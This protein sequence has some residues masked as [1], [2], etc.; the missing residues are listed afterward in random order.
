M[1]RT[2]VQFSLL[3]LLVF[4]SMTGAFAQ[5]FANSQAGE[6]IGNNASSKMSVIKEPLHKPIAQADPALA[7]ALAAQPPVNVTVMGQVITP[8]V[9]E[10]RYGAPD[11]K[12]LVEQSGGLTRYCAHQFFVFKANED[13]L[14]LDARRNA[15]YKFEDGDLLLVET[16]ARHYKTLGTSETRHSLADIH[17]VT[18]VVL[19]NVLDRP[20]LLSLSPNDAKLAYLLSLLNQDRSAMVG[21]EGIAPPNASAVPPDALI[22]PNMIFSGSIIRFEPGA[23]NPNTLPQLPEPIQV[24]KSSKVQVLSG[25]TE[26]SES[27]WARDP[28]TL[29]VQPVK[30]QTQTP[31]SPDPGNSSRIDTLEETQ[32]SENP[33][34]A[35]FAQ[36]EE[37]SDEVLNS[38]APE[39]LLPAVK[40]SDDR[41]MLSAQ[42]W[43]IIATFVTLMVLFLSAWY[44]RQRQQK[45]GIKA[46]NFVESRI[47]TSPETP[48][49][50]LAEAKTSKEPAEPRGVDS[51]VIDQSEIANVEDESTM[52]SAEKTEVEV[53][54]QVDDPH[55]DVLELEVLKNEGPDES[56]LKHNLAAYSFELSAYDSARKGDFIDHET[57][58]VTIDELGSGHEIETFDPVEW[59]R[60][61]AAQTIGS[62]EG[63]VEDAPPAESLPAEAQHESEDLEE[64]AATRVQQSILGTPWL[65]ELSS[66]LDPQQSDISLDE[67]PADTPEAGEEIKEAQPQASKKLSS[68][69][70]AAQQMRIDQAHSAQP[71]PAK[72][73]LVPESS[74]EPTLDQTGSDSERVN[75]P[76]A[77]SKWLR[78]EDAPQQPEENLDHIFQSIMRDRR[79]K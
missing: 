59:P 19:L 12:E 69:R 15:D 58:E 20:V 53:Q 11:L 18:Q 26:P 38:D 61:T 25:A 65:Q 7:H 78:M 60:E 24:Q 39:A 77:A 76:S 72:Q 66:N 64:E 71:Q 35:A 57:F 49:G 4:A 50:Q 5:N 67:Q 36:F 31:F 29:M 43:R 52:P 33:F 17:P 1:S 27:G 68:G 32:S 16:S 79:N 9:Y 56:E 23:I 73:P 22:A 42:Q 54:A 74:T 37:S 44:I 8:G 63:N 51:A 10:F 2:L 46:H 28:G 34:E 48:A 62:V 30:S 6:V 75:P 45:S 14:Q 3:T 70:F 47:S 55:D 41:A 21:V 40:S 13:S